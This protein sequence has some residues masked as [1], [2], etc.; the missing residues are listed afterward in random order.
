MI[1]DFDWNTINCDCGEMVEVD[2]KD[3]SFVDDCIVLETY[4]KC[5]KC[6]TILG[7][8]YTFDLDTAE[9]IDNETA[10]QEYLAKF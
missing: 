1:Q 7:M 10:K 9:Q 4:T 5:H 3:I 8:R 2:Y 6:G